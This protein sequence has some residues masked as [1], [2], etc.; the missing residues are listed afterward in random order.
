MEQREQSDAC[1]GSAKRL[2]STRE[3]NG[4]EDSPTLTGRESATLWKKLGDSLGDSPGL[5]GT[6]RAR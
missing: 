5:S 6:K 2:N 4:L 3:E 1:I